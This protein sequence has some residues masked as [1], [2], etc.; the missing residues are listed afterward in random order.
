MS[1][2]T[3]PKRLT[4]FDQ[5]ADV[6]NHARKTGELEIQVK[7]HDGKTTTVSLGPDG[8]VLEG[9]TLEDW[10]AEVERITEAKKGAW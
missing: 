7:W 8:E 3:P 2:F 6:R 10:K 4:R 5:L 9:P 1:A